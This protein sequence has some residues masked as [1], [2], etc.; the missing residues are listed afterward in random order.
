MNYNIKNIG[1]KSSIYI[2]LIIFSLGHSLFAQAK[3]EKINSLMKYCNINLQFNGNILVAEH[4][5]IIYHHSFGI[6]NFDPV[7]S[8]NLGSQFRL[9]SVSKQFTA[10]AIMILEERGKLN[11]D[12]DIN[13]YL[14][15]FP[16]KKITIRHLLTHTSGLP[17]Y[18]SLF[19]QYWDT[20]KKDDSDKKI[21][22]NEDVLTM[23]C[24]YHKDPLF[25]PG[26]KWQYCNTGYVILALIVNRV[27]GEPFEKFLYDNIF[28]PLNMTNTLVY[29]AIRNDSITNRVY[30]Y[31]LAMNGV[32]YIPN[33]FH[34]LNGV[35]GDGGVYST[36]GDLFKWDQALYTEKLVSRQT[37]KKAFTPV[38][39]NNG[40]TFNYGFG[41]SI[42]T[43][44]TGKKCVRHGGSW[45]GFRTYILRE[46]QDNNTIILLT[47]NT[48]NYVD[49]IINKLASILHSKIFKYP[50]VSIDYIVGK[51]LVTQGID[52]AISLYHF[53]KN[54][55]F[56]KYNFA[57]KKLNSLGYRLISLNKLPEA[58]AVL[59]L[60]VESFPKSFNTYD[61]LGEA[62]ML[63]GNTDLAIK[64]YE[65]VL[66]LNPENTNAL[67]KLKQ[68]QKE[69]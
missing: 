38:A 33:D 9:G 17:D 8:L 63:Y 64:N 12:D 21:A 47:N 65:K 44:L 69:D 32:D 40:T 46:I 57:E 67:E 18:I 37:L 4:G 29:S 42:D 53:L 55:E 16:Y 51:T 34:Y 10:M 36:T 5:K 60:N 58:I 49:D 15:E 68:L 28:K 41:W 50:K 62:Y 31:S 22:D 6:A 19:D 25:N 39:L 20:E 1:F 48:S 30:G 66:E 52:S 2:T 26:E 14:P 61:S 23:L 11:Y 56:D 35:A 54:K 27:S 7:G 43:S 24:K 3:S 45:V 59:K 13:I